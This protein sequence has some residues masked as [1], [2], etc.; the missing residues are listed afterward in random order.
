MNGFF[1]HKFYKLA[2]V[3]SFW[4][5]SSIFWIRRLFGVKAFENAAKKNIMVL[6]GTPKDWPGGLERMSN[7]KPYF[8]KEGIQ[9]DV[10]WAYD[11]APFLKTQR[12]PISWQA[13]FFHIGKLFRRVGSMKKMK[14]YAVAYVQREFVPYYDSRD[15]RFDQLAIDNHPNVVFDFYDADYEGT[16]LVTYFIFGHA[17]KITVASRYL[18]EKV[19]EYNSDVLFTRLSLPTPEIKLYEKQKSGKVRIGWTGSPGNAENLIRLDDVFAQIALKYPEVEFHFVC[20][21]PPELNYHGIVWYDMNDDSFDYPQ[22]LSSLDIGI[23][24]YFSDDDRTKAKTAMKSLEFWANGAAL[25]CSPYG[26]SDQIK[27]KD[28]CL[29]AQSLEAWASA[30]ELLVKDTILRN[31]LA[32]RGRQTFERFHS[33]EENYEELRDFLLE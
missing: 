28:N 6:P 1:F 15:V 4:Y 12:N 19:G 13:L 2:W 7:W 33:Y 18:V 30:I 31:E 9:Y 17:Q 5:L 20:R 25:V 29:V 21:T 11:Q 10:F 32:Q 23:V 3:G 27:D 8:E 16:P 14:N 22:W 24:P 26:M